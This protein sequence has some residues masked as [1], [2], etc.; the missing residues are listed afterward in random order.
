MYY[1]NPMFC[2]NCKDKQASVL[3]PPNK[4]PLCIDCFISAFEQHIHSTIVTHKLF[5]P[6]ERIAIAI[7]GGKDST[8]LAFLLNE[9]NKRHSYGLDLVLLSVDEGIKDY[10]DLSI[11]TVEG[12]K[13][14]YNLPLK[15]VSFQ[16]YFNHTLDEIVSKVGRKR[17]CTY[18]GVFRRQALDKGARE[19]G[20]SQIVTGHNADDFAETVLMNLLRGDFKR[21]KKAT[22]IKTGALK[23]KISRTK[24]FKYT[25]ER[26][27]V[28]YAFYKGL[29]YFSLECLYSPGAYRGN[30]RVL[31]KEL[32]KRKP[33]TIL[34]IINANDELVYE[35]DEQTLFKCFKCGEDTSSSNEVCKA[36]DFIDQLSNITIEEHKQLEI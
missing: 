9:L 23:D 22:M 20:V 12:N 3:R 17:N 7:S 16:E 34:N 18:C 11:E 5:S 33:I 4:V 24:P 13:K 15:V 32:E 26:E 6:G 35:C 19:L 29:K 10:R 21:M 14:D 1:F 28:M 8:V 27:I 36:C 25:Y 30:V 31:I 2:I